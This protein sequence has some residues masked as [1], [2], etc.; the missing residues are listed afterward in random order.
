M[1]LE[2]VKAHVKELFAQRMPPEYVFH[3]HF[4][5]AETAAHVLEIGTGELLGEADLEDLEIAALFH[6]VGYAEAYEGHEEASAKM[7]KAFL[8]EKNYSKERTETV[9]ALILSTR[10]A[11]AADNLLEGIICDADLYHLGT[12]QFFVRNALLREEL[13]SALNIEKTNKE[14]VLENIAFL[15]KHK[16]HT[17]YARKELSVQ[18]SKNLERLRKD[19]R[20]IEKEEEQ[21]AKE[22]EKARKADRPDRGVETMLRNSLR[23]HYDLSA[24]ADRKA[25]VMLS[26]NS[27][28]ISVAFAGLVP[29]FN[30]DPELIVP[31]FILLAVN[32]ITI[33][34][35]VK[36][37]IPNITIGTFKKEDVLNKTANLLFFGNFHKMK[38]DDFVWGMKEM[39]KDREFLYDA[40]LRDFFQLGLV[41]NRK[42]VLLRRCYWVFLIGLSLAILSYFISIG[43]RHL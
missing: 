4:H 9:V 40:M 28:I 8:E 43:A 20:S 5:T 16:Y 6:D 34:F 24:I 37:V 35:A 26:V 22:A 30:K 18:R 11:S 13:K 21:A 1:I 38:R 19:L 33:F 32:L 2:E 41:L 7:A 10:M 36:A 17:N 39:M 27:I 29:R 14:W 3:D 12:D 15:E 23:G 42:Y 25:G 31:T